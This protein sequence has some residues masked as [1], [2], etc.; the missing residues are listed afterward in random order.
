MDWDTRI[1]G[2]KA[3]IAIAYERMKLHDESIGEPSRVRDQ[4]SA[5]GSKLLQGRTGSQAQAGDHEDGGGVDGKTLR[6]KVAR[7]RQTS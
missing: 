2:L 7:V 5:G 6:P 3:R 1:F 4:L